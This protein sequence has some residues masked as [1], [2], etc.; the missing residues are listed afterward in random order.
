[1]INDKRPGG[2]WRLLARDGDRNVEAENDGVFDE[3]VVDR[4][5]HL[6]QMT[7]DTWWMR[8]GDS[9]VDIQ[10]LP[11]GRAEISIERGVYE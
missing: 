1:M 7:E 10:V 9:R 4:W 3:L 11:T 6:E 8:V 5:L 2:S